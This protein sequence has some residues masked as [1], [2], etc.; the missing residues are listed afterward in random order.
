MA[1]TIDIE[2]PGTDK[3]ALAAAIAQLRPPRQRMTAVVVGN[4]IAAAEKYTGTG[5]GFT[6]R[7]A[8]PLINDL[9]GGPLRLKRMTA[10]TR[11]DLYGI[12]GYSSQTLPTILA[13]LEAELFTPLA[14]A[15]IMPDIV[16]GLAL[17]ENDL[18]SGRTLA[19]MQASVTEFIRNV[20][21]RYPGV[22]IWL[23]TPHLNGNRTGGGGTQYVQAD[24]LAITAWMLTLDNS[25]DIFVTD[26]SGTY[27]DATYPERAETQDFTAS[28]SGTTM[29]VT[30]AGTAVIGMRMKISGAGI[31][32]GTE[33]TAF[34]T[35]TGGTGTYTI[36]NSHTLSAQ[37]V[38]LHPWT[39]DNVH[40]NG[41]G[42]SEVA[43]VA[44]EDLG[45]IAPEWKHEARHYS[46][47]PA[48]GGTASATATGVTGTKPTGTGITVGSNCNIVS[49]AEQ[50]G[51]LV[52]IQGLG[53]TSTF[54]WLNGAAI[55]L[56]SPA[57]VETFMEVEIVEGA[58][59]IRLLQLDSRVN[60]GSGNNFQYWRKN[61]SSE[62][63]TEYQN[64]DILM[65]RAGPFVPASG[66]I[67]AVTN[68]LGVYPKALQEGTDTIKIRI[69]K[70]SVAV[71]S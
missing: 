63:D 20:Q 43:R 52:E 26:L 61:S 14:T 15:S 48:L 49:T 42:T 34:G 23:W 38:V 56:S 65:M 66:A 22:I 46:T 28:F 67:S 9:A 2:A 30:D 29:T 1:E 51:W 6:A 54:S 19:Q 37:A 55:S 62:A 69:R 5:T 8:L 59:N 17:L 45:R 25:V 70:E 10:S 31:T 71:V 12:Y 41:R 11:A 40:R 32:T 3:A 44:V 24:F 18:L 21:A 36:S 16:I 57:Q 33:I 39:D 4:S 13:D 47:N 53:S 35:G 7:A 50:S 64:G 58:E 60:D 27:P 68:Y